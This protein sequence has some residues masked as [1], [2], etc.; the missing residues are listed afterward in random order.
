MSKPERPF[1]EE[2][3][4]LKEKLLEMAS[5]AEEQIGRA[6]RSLKDRKEDLACQVLDY[7][8]AINRLDIEIDE[9]AM[10]ILAL[11]QP[12]AA[13]LRFITSAMKIGSDLERIGDLAVNIAERTL[14][15]L[16]SPQLKPLIDI[17]RMAEMVQNMV[18]DAINAFVNGDA[19]LAK[20]VCERDDEVDH[21]N[22]QVFRELLTYMLED[23]STIHRAVDLIL[24]GRHLER[25]ADHATNIGEDVIYMVK[26]KTIKHHVEEGRLTNLQPCT[27]KK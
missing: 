10:R 7:E 9:A 18:R 5:R 19:D 17:P 6:V 13:D 26:G 15:I 20:N 22:N 1:D 24:V 14:E 25:I 4:D 23:A 2:L 8:E 21:L 27:E 11:R 16:K 12:M 3:K